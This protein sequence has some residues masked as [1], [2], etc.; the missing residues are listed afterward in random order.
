MCDAHIAEAAATDLQKVC[1]V[2]VCSGE[3][4]MMSPFR[5]RRP[6]TQITG[7]ATFEALRRNNPNVPQITSWRTL[8]AQIPDGVVDP[9]ETLQILAD[10]EEPRHTFRYGAI[11]IEGTGEIGFLMLG[12]VAGDTGSLHM[13]VADGTNSEWGPFPAWRSETEWSAFTIKAMTTVLARRRAARAGEHSGRVYA[14][15]HSPLRAYTARTGRRTFIMS[16]RVTKTEGIAGLP[17][18]ARL[19]LWEALVL[20]ECPYAYPLAVAGYRAD[21]SLAGILTL[22]SMPSMHNDVFLCLFDPDGVHQNFGEWDRGD[23][24]ERVMAEG[25]QVFGALIAGER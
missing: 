14:A 3:Q 20:E 23:D 19:E 18:P 2:L 4:V 7:D 1:V 25:R 10:I 8:G 17:A 12:R 6:I 11:L 21:D 13:C 9:G 22:E 5:K 15:E 24:K 16:W